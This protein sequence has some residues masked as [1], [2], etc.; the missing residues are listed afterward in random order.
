MVTRK[1]LFGSA[2]FYEGHSKMNG[3]ASKVAKPLGRLDFRRN[4]SKSASLVSARARVHLDVDRQ[5]EYQ[6]SVWPSR[7]IRDGRGDNA[8]AAYWAC[9]NCNKMAFYTDP[10]NEMRTQ[11]VRKG[12]RS[13][14][15]T[16]V[17]QKCAI[18]RGEDLEQLKHYWIT[19]YNGEEEFVDAP[20]FTF[21]MD[22]RDSIG[23]V[24]L[25][26]NKPKITNLM[27]RWLKN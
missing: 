19:L 27:S 20:G 17:S 4:C 11:K 16:I 26:E 21:A 13:F 18:Q 2:K 12:T 1:S 3:Y 7:S 6:H 10:D 14:D 15:K 5:C 9:A 23:L 25:I 8:R 22:S 24:S